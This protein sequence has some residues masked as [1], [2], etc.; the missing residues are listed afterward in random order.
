MRNIRL[1]KRET[2][3]DI[4]LSLFRGIK[5]QNSSFTNSQLYKL[6]DHVDFSSMSFP[7][8]ITSETHKSCTFKVLQYPSNQDI[9]QQ[10]KLLQI[11]YLHVAYSSSCLN[12]VCSKSM[13]QNLMSIWMGTYT[14]NTIQAQRQLKNL[15]WKCGNK[16][17]LKRVKI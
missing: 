2:K 1:E 15:M 5:Q 10:L 11:M 3:I 9:Q 14:N 16:E 13:C 4:C 17:T 6:Q 12:H 7:L 8:I